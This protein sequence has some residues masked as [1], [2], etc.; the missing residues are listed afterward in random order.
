MAGSYFGPY[1]RGGKPQEPCGAN[2]VSNVN[3]PL[4]FTALL[5]VQQGPV[6]S[7]G[8][9]ALELEL[10]LSVHIGVVGSPGGCG[11]ISRPRGTDPYH[12]FN[13]DPKQ[14][15]RAAEL[16]E[17]LE[18]PEREPELAWNDNLTGDAWTSITLF[19]EGCDMKGRTAGRTIHHQIIEPAR[20]QGADAERYEQL[21]A[22]LLEMA[23]ARDSPAWHM[24]QRGSMRPPPPHHP[25]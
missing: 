12:T 17:A 6:G 5:V 9:A 22:C 1:A 8:Q 15:A 13:I 23:E 21:L 2:R 19:V 14:A 11:F 4:Y 16:I 3:E 10:A 20:Y 7:M 24:V 18:L 25:G